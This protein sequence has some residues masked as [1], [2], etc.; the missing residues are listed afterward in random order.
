M[1]SERKA[2]HTFVAGQRLSS[3]R[4]VFPGNTYG[5]GYGKS[6]LDYGPLSPV[7]TLVPSPEYPYS[8][9]ADH[10]RL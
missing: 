5:L 3:C 7:C 6:H 10:R 9:Y 2:L 8:H 4:H 1:A